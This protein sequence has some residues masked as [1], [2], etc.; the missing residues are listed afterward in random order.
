MRSKFKKIS[1][2]K[3]VTED[4]IKEQYQIIRKDIL[5]LREDL[6]KGYEMAR[7]MVQEQK[8]YFSQLLKNK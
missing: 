5:K 4:N 2:R 3:P 7:G 6:S 1:K 8:G